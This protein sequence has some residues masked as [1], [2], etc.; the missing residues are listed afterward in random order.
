MRIV[1]SW[2]REY[3]EWNGSVEQLADSLTRLGIEVESIE[4]VGGSLAKVVVGTVL[5]V[6]AHPKADRLRVCTVFDG[7]QSRRIVCG[8]PNVRQGQ[9]VAL[10]LPGAEL[11]NGTHIELRSIRGI[12]SEGMICSEQELG[13][14]NDHDGILTFEGTI[15]PGTLLSE[16]FPPDVVLEIGI[17]PNR[18]DALS[19]FGIARML[20]ASLGLSSSL[21]CMKVA[22]SFSIPCTIEL[23]VPELCI[24]YA[25]RVLE[26]VQIVP[27]PI[28]MKRRL[29]RSGIRPRNLVVDVTNYVMLECGQPLHAFDVATIHGGH[30]IV[31]PARDGETL[32]T[33]DGI[34]RTLD[35]TVLC[36]ADAERP[37]AI[38]GVMG[39]AYSAISES[40]TH[41]LIES[42]YFDPS[43]IRRTS[44]ALGLQT[45]ASYRFERG[46][47][48]EM[49]PYALDRA[50]ALIA[51][52]T[53]ARVS[54]ML[55]VYPHPRVP[56]ELSLRTDRVTRI[57]G[58]PL[59][60]DEVDEALRRSGLMARRKRS[61]L[62]TVNVPSYRTD[63][64][65][66][67]DLI[68]EVAIARDY[69]TIP[70]SPV[71]VVPFSAQKIPQTLAVPER[72]GELRRWL[73]DVGF[74]ES[75]SFS[76]QDPS[77]LIEPERCLELANPLGRE[78]SVLRQWL[79]PAMVEIL[80]RN[81]RYG[82][83]SMRLFEIGKVFFT[84][85]YGDGIAEEHE[86]LVLAIA[87]HHGPRHW[88]EEHRN[89][90]LYDIKGILDGLFKRFRVSYQWNSHH[91]PS[92]VQSWLMQPILEVVHD[93]HV[94]GI[95]GQLDQRLAHSADVP[96]AAFLAELSLE[97]IYGTLRQVQ[98][99]RPPSPYPSV[100]RD[101]AFIVD[102]TIP[103]QILAET[104][105]ATAGEL[106]QTVELF[107]VYEHPSLGEG[108][109]S[110]AFTLT[111]GSK[112]RT[113]TDEEVEHAIEH[114]VD[115]LA[116]RHG[117][118]LRRS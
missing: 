73:A 100:E 110:L 42:A 64:T 25:A 44:K 54:T 94:I 23:S 108:N 98:H 16:L 58:T 7:Q 31:R 28:W 19:Y 1:L 46:T 4:S 3:V 48:I 65:Q 2:L 107:D 77:T 104:I 105:Q 68:E 5:E 50:A 89:V 34:E 84:S 69:E 90:D 87:G 117:A 40:T 6:L 112:E 80:S 86:H 24:R 20:S 72:R 82:A 93:G 10:A 35:S 88:L 109:K 32:T 60:D 66:E 49:I 59:S 81:A 113:L 101:L 57:L 91:Q 118:Q 38:A 106:L 76:L 17:T 114:V 78:R 62:V 83:R 45:E 27:S 116:Q 14:G 99:Y 30:I 74:H 103:A 39:G 43:S 26:H 47:D 41:V 70:A 71:A 75:L 115:S 53:G 22:E 56:L 111:F 67:I 51:A 8:T 102:R 85:Q 33:L 55:D 79:I 11:P 18:A 36:I 21:P 52:Y 15:Q 12:E 9:R 37:H 63:I 92:D 95:V 13:L 61:G 29:E 97:P 96:E